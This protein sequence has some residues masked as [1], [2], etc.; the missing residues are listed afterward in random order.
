MVSGRNLRTVKQVAQ[1]FPAFS[2]GALR[3]M[4]FTSKSLGLTGA[5]FRVG[6][7]V[8][9]DVEAF[10]CWIQEQNRPHPK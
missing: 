5:I 1:T 7:R 10:E 8:L 4:I 3:W 9:I 2:V 6:K